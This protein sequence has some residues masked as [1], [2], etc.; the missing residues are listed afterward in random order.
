[1]HPRTTELLAHLERHRAALRRAIDKVPV[2]L[3]TTR[4][5]A[6]RWSVAS[7]IDHVALVER[8]VTMGLSGKLAEARAH[9]LDAET[10]AAS[11]IDERAMAR[12]LNRER[13]VQSGEA[14]EPRANVTAGEAWTA[15]AEA[16]DA[17]IALLEKADGLAV[18]GVSLPHPALGPLSFYQWMVFLGGHDARHSLQ[19]DE[20]GRQVAAS[21]R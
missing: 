7:V 6:D 3:R 14:S 2:A 8:R 10:A 9:G 19:I 4:P 20:V 17:T 13:R 11:V 16:R 12:Y 1:V 18:D 15:A 21:G 5:A